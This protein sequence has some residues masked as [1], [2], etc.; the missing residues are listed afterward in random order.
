MD[1]KMLYLYSKTKIST[2]GPL[3]PKLCLHTCL[4]VMQN[5]QKLT[6]NCCISRSYE[7]LTLIFCMK[8]VDLAKD[9]I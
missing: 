2:S 4:D 5:F 7:G 3:G 1:R 9:K 8:F 6:S